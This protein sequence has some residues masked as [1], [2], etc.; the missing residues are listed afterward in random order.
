MVKYVLQLLW[1]SKSFS[2]VEN[3]ICIV[4]LKAPTCH[5]MQMD[6]SIYCL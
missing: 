6:Q 5:I 1:I 4:F 2:L 3:F